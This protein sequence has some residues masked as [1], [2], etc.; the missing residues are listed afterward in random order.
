M[1]NLDQR[2]KKESE[3]ILFGVRKGTEIG[4]SLDSFRV[5]LF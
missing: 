5:L 2:E 3:G 1:E 4:I